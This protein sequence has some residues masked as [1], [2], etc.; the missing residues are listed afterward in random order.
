MG[1][2]L[3]SFARILRILSSWTEMQHLLINV[4]S[5]QA[6]LQVPQ[7]LLLCQQLLSLLLN[8]SLHSEFDLLQLVLFTLELFLLQPDRLVSQLFTRNRSVGVVAV[9]SPGELLG[10]VVLVEEVVR[11]LLKVGKMCVEQCGSETSKVRVFGV[12]NLDD[13]PGVF[14]C[15]DGLAID[16]DVLFGSNDGERHKTAKLG[17]V[18]NRLFVVLLDVVREVV[19]RDAVVFNVLPDSLLELLSLA[20]SHRVG[21]A[22]DGDDVDTWRETTHE[23]D[24]DLAQR[25][26]GRSDEVE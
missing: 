5:L 16:N 24:V 15:S 10:T 3:L 8:L 7:A 11:D 17:V 12:V 1:A 4:L 19:D 14:A 25:V 26:T 13:T 2:V 21:L 18:G 9:N 6:R 20:E 22:D 23:L